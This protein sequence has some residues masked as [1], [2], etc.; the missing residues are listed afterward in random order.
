M[1]EKGKASFNEMPM[2]TFRDS[3]V[4]GR[5]RGSCKVGDAM[6]SEEGAEFEILTT[7]ICV[8]VFDAFVKLIFDVIF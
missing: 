2:T 4:L 7:I 3:I 1:V 8:E 5:V 6:F